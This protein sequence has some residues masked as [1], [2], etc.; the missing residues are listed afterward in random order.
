MKNKENCIKTLLT[1][2]EARNDKLHKEIEENEKAMQEMRSE[3]EQIL[4]SEELLDPK[5]VA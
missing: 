3:L 4:E 5:V 2:F 1:A